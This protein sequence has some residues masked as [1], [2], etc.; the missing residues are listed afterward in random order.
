LNCYACKKKQSIC[1]DSFLTKSKLSIK[2]LLLLLYF[3]SVKTPIEQTALMLDLS[4]TMII[5]WNNMIHEICSTKFSHETNPQLGGPDHIIQI[6]KS[7]IYRPKHNQGHALFEPSK[8][9]F[10]IYDVDRKIGVIKLVPSRSTD[11]LLPIIKKYVIPG[12]EIHSDQWAAYAG[13][14]SITVDP[15]YTH[16]TVNHSRHFKDPS[17]GVHTNNVK[18]YW[19]AIK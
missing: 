13:I 11:V 17:T 7:V 4:Q 2:Q 18:A 3:W 1:V 10:A 8:W 9:I 12:T 5:S 15:P 14:P 6:D 16:H 19:L